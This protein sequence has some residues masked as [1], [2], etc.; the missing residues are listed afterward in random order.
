MHTQQE[1]Q[2]SKA[3]HARVSQRA[4]RAQSVE[5]AA[6]LA[7]EA[8]ATFAS[9]RERLESFGR[10]L[11]GLRKRVEAELGGSDIAHMRRVRTASNRLEIGGRTLIHFSFEPI[12]FSIGVGA[13]WAHKLLET[14]EIGHTTLHGTYDRIPGA[15]GLSSRAFRWKTPIDEA[16]WRNAHNVRHHQYT[17][18]AGRDPDVDFGGLRLSDE[19][20]RKTLHALQPLSNVATWFGFTTAINVHITGLIDV[21]T[22]GRKAHVLKDRSW[23]EI[24]SAHRAGL[25]KPM[26]YYRREYVFFPLLAGPFFWKTLLGNF[27]SEVGKD[28][29]AGATIYCGH[30]GA[31]GYAPGTRAKTRAEWYVMQVEASRDFEVPAVIALLCGGL[32]RQIEHHLFPRLPPNRLREIAPRVRALCEEHG[33]TYRTGTWPATLRDVLRNLRRLSAPDPQKSV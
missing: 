8:G 21:Y 13:L 26:R 30:V 2:P 27:L 16:A 6:T 33:V 17:N 12:G 18:I 19:V 4:A 15:E 10:C 1:R 28:L 14:I 7:S 22:P 32:E 31:Q 24:W 9:D 23:R 20:A 25:G 5:A 11:D 29:Y 3:E